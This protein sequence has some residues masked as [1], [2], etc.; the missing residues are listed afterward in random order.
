MPNAGAIGDVAGLGFG[1]LER[2]DRA[3]PV[4]AMFEIL[5][6]EGP[7]DGAVAQRHHLVGDAGI[8]QRLGADDRAGAAGAIDDDGG[9]GIGRRA[10]GAQ[11]EFGA[12]HA[13]RAGDVHGGVFVEAADIEDGDIGLARDQ[14]RDFV[15]GQ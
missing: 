8:D 15:G 5:L 7:A 10:A 13:D 6:G 3:A 1:A 14:G 4:G 12:G 9:R 11:H 2:A